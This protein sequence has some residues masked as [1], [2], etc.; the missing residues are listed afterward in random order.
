MFLIDVFVQFLAIQS[1]AV[2]LLI[3]GGE[4]LDDIKQRV[5]DLDIVENV[6]FLGVR[7]DVHDLIQALDILLFPSFFEGL[8]GV[9]LECQVSGLPCLISDTITSEVQITQNVVFNSLQNTA[10]EWA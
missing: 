4:L 1:N 2:L 8:P 5:V 6:K 3:G 9:V 7:N 10:E